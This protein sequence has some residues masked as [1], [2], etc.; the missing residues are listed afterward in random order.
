MVNLPPTLSLIPWIHSDPHTSMFPLFLTQNS[1]LAM[2]A[3]YLTVCQLLDGGDRILSP[4]CDLIGPAVCLTPS[5]GLAAQAGPA[6]SLLS[7]S[8]PP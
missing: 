6:C 2:T 4:I 5:L 3:V 1:T 7:S 8:L